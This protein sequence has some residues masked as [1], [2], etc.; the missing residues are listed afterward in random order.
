MTEQIHNNSIP[1][2]KV[3]WTAEDIGKYLDLS[4]RTVAE[5]YAVRPDFPL[6][7]KPGGMRRWYAHEI[8]TWLESTRERK[9]AV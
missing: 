2:D 1:W 9:V 8:E 4:P 5:R 6:A 7:V 3:L